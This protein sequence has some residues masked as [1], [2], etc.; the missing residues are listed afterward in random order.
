MTAAPQII[1]DRY[2]V[3]TVLNHGSFGVVSLAKDTLKKNRLV[4]LKCIHKQKESTAIDEAKEEIAVHERLGSHPYI[5]S[6]LD[7][8][9]TDDSTY[10]VMEYY[11]EGDLY[12]AIRAEKGPRDCGTVLEFMLQLI[13]AVEFAHSKGV[14]HRDIKPENILLASDG[15]VR[16]AD[17]GLSTTI[18]EN[19]EFGVGSERY[20]APEL[21]DKTI[22]SYDAEKADIWSLGICLLN[23]LFARN[24]FTIAC[25]KDKLFLDFAS[26]REALFDIFPTLSYDV[27]AVLRHALTIDP[28]N[29]SLE[30]MRQELLKVNLWT[31]DDD[32]CDDYVDDYDRN[33]TSATYS[34][35]AD[36]RNPS[37]VAPLPVITTSKPSAPALNVY[38]VGAPTA[39]MPVPTPASIGTPALLSSI[40]PTNTSREPLRT[41]S[42]AEVP[43]ESFGTSFTWDRTMQFT[44]P[45]PSF[46]RPQERR[47]Q[48]G[49][50]RLSNVISKEPSLPMESL[51]EEDEMFAMDGVG[52]ALQHIETSPRNTSSN[53]DSSD[54]STVPSLV[55]SHTLGGT[56]GSSLS[57]ARN[58]YLPSVAASDSVAI[59]AAQT[60]RPYMQAALGTSGGG[61]S[62]ATAGKSWSDLIFDDDEDDFD[63]NQLL[64]ALSSM[65]RLPFMNNFAKSPAGT[66][67][68]AGA[69]A[70]KAPGVTA[71]HDS[72]AP[73]VATGGDGPND[74]WVLS[75]WED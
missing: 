33:E 18:A 9:E 25:Q 62:A 64:Q 8:F 71:A 69:G 66:K 47:K 55:Q 11:P 20:M 48:H 65:P 39:S 51:A 30:N 49:A 27:F 31:T 17:W 67:T 14:Y 57:K 56:A 6:L 35:D 75:N 59:P 73:A 45:T 68:G 40:V 58:P 50:S 5:A 36:S 7:H 10:L 22:D 42:V 4:A 26:S 44:P 74:D 72:A 46:F 52:E 13:D 61:G 37:L 15:S 43:V 2:K 28:D 23:V 60:A 29:R 53:S 32:Y 16:L 21:F 63:E 12:E 38:D 1:N 34:D 3:V 19:T 54:V 41:P 70:A 24:P